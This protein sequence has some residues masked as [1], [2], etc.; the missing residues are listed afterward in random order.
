MEDAATPGL[1]LPCTATE[2]MTMTTTVYSVAFTMVEAE[3][4][5]GL[6]LLVFIQTVE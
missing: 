1:Q 5:I 4:N 3:M 2:M 6:E